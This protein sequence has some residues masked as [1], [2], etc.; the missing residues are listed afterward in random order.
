M[1]WRVGSREYGPC[2]DLFIGGYVAG[3][4]HLQIHKGGKK[5]QIFNVLELIANSDIERLTHAQSHDCQVHKV[6]CLKSSRPP[7]N[8]EEQA[9]VDCKLPLFWQKVLLLHPVSRKLLNNHFHISAQCWCLG[10]SLC[11]CFS[12]HSGKLQHGL[13]WG[14]GVLK[15][16][17]ITNLISFKQIVSPPKPAQNCI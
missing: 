5:K 16:V 9:P 17:N 12:P 8:H 1:S 7:W 6:K 15:L 10:L 14:P 4:N 13:P 2:L 3:H 11:S